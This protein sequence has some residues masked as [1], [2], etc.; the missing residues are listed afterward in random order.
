M[1]CAIVKMTVNSL[2]ERQVKLG[3]SLKSSL[4]LFFPLLGLSIIYIVCVLFGLLMLIIPGFILSLGWAL[5]FHVKIIEGKSITESL[6]RSWELSQGYKRWIFLM[7]IILGVLGAVIGAIFSI[8]VAFLGNPQTAFLDGGTASFWITNGIATGLSQMVS[9]TIS[10]VG[11]TAT[12]L[13]IR[14]VKE[15]V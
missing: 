14:R 6:S 11:L 3:E 4:G 9:V 15:G 10:Y 7:M 8:P 12:Y 2:N 13:E 5:A 1:Y